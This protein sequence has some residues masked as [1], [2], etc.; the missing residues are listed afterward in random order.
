MPQCYLFFD[1]SERSTL[2]AD[3]GAAREAW[4]QRKLQR[5]YKTFG[6]QFIPPPAEPASAVS[7]VTVTAAPFASSWVF[8]APTM[9]QWHQPESITATTTTILTSTPQQQQQQQ[10]LLLIADCLL[11]PVVA[12]A[13]GAAA[14]AAVTTVTVAA[15]SL[16]LLAPRHTAAPAPAAAPAA[17]HSDG[18]D[19]VSFETA[20]T[21]AR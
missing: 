14:A 17:L 11:S 16:P 12:N 8:P 13:A 20:I 7:S 19:D 9:L 5:Y 4:H 21:A 10:Q 2:T 15:P 1:D 18:N 3:A 6:N